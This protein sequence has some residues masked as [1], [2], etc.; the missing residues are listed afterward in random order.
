[1]RSCFPVL[2]CRNW[3]IN[4]E[5]RSRN[6]SSRYD[7]SWTLINW[8]K[9]VFRD[10]K[11]PA[12]RI[13]SRTDA[14]SGRGQP[15]AGIVTDSPILSIQTGSSSDLVPTL[16]GIFDNM[17]ANQQTS[18][19]HSTVNG[20]TSTVATKPKLP[21]NNI[22][23]NKLNN[24]GAISSKIFVTG[25]RHFP[26]LRIVEPGD[27]ID[28]NAPSK[29]RPRRRLRTFKRSRGFFVT[30]ATDTAATIKPSYPT[31]LRYSR[32]FPRISMRSTHFSPHQQLS[33]CYHF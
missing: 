26:V 33:S 24:S 23:N 17:I 10:T 25:E 7:Q 4:T 28:R 19:D 3:W 18:A 30:R 20:N 14:R 6:S 21:N 5:S 13:T 22:I 2:T 32:G 9:K 16:L 27:E 15:S 12:G 31:S 29:S 11:P 1:M 8:K